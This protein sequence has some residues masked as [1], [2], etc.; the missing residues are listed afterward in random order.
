MKILIVDSDT[1][2][3]KTLEV[4]LK[5]EGFEVVCSSDGSEALL[6]LDEVKP[7]IVVTDIMLPG[8]SGFEILQSAKN[9]E[10]SVMVIIVSVIGQEKVVEEAFEFGANDYIPKPYNLALFVN[11]IK[12]L[13]KTQ[14]QMAILAQAIPPSKRS[15]V[16]EKLAQQEMTLAH[17][18]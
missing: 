9:M 17:K 7:D 6:K 5:N 15:A 12:R 13:I 18:E 14:Q 10:Y 16:M 4:K 8:A 11:R 2:L 3:L 1:L